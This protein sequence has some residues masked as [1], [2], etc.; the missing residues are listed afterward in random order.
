MPSSALAWD[1]NVPHDAADSSA[2]C[3]NTYALQPDFVQLAQEGLV[4]LHIAEQFILFSS[5][6]PSRL[7]AN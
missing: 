5:V 7:G 6:E 1:A 2:R 3:E 4:V